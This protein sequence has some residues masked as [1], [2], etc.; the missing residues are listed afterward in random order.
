MDISEGHERECG[1][2]KIHVPVIRE[3]IELEPVDPIE[4]PMDLVE[5]PV[6]PTGPSKTHMQELYDSH[7]KLIRVCMIALLAISAIILTVLTI[8]NEGTVTQG[9]TQDE[10]RFWVNLLI[11]YTVI[12]VIQFCVGLLV[13][14]YNIRVNYSRKIVHIF[15][16]VWPQLLD[17]II[18]D[19]D[20]TIYIELWNIQII[21][22]FLV[23]F[24]EPIRKKI[25]I[26]DVMFKSID[27]PE[28]RPYTLYW[29]VTQL[30]ASLV[31]I[32]G[33]VLLFDSQDLDTNW[34]FI[35]L[36]VLT[37]GDGLAEPI[38]IRFATPSTTYKVKG[39]CVNRE[40]T[41]SYQGSSWVWLVGMASICIFIESFTTSQKIF[42][43][44]VLPVILTMV[45][46]AAPHTW[47]NPLILFTGYVILYLSS[48]L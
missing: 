44:I 29:S 12:G 36:L 19:F 34:V 18:L 43:L 27:R 48:I 17:K 2:I 46:A 28:D 32:A 5:P 47:D 33:A 45:E 1:H 15:Y 16:F 10:H 4:P 22:L 30:L 21:M 38:G 13:V 26:C 14:H 40:Y 6:E 42:N 20:K 8:N 3:Q 23:L 7:Y 37:V 9:E 35:P 39:M 31:V 11:K 41:R 25:W 24:I